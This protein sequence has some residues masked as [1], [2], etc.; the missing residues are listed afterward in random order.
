[1][2]GGTLAFQAATRPNYKL[3]CNSCNLMLRFG[4]NAHSVALLRKA[5]PQSGASA[6]GSA[7]A[8][9]AELRTCGGC[10]SAL[11]RVDFHRDKTPLPG[12]ETAY[13]GCLFCDPVLAE[14]IAA[15]LFA[16]VRLGSAPRGAG[17]S[18]GRGRGRGGGGARGGGG[19]GC[20]EAEAGGGFGGGGEERSEDR[21]PGARGGRGRGRGG[22]GGGRGRRGGADEAETQDREERGARAPEGMTRAARERFAARYN[23]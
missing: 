23:G 13:E 1:M 22:G 6:G 17:G 14:T 11:F 19:G 21:G 9:A 5:G 2:C 7:A 16:R 3:M 4:A 18:R 8:A 20:G 10:G 15:T 12:G